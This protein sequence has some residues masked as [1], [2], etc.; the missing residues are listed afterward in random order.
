MQQHYPQHRHRH[1]QHRQQAGHQPEQSEQ[2]FNTIQNTTAPDATPLSTVNNTP[3]SASYHPY[4][5]RPPTGHSPA[6]SSSRPCSTSDSST[7]VP[8][9]H[10]N[11]IADASS[12]TKTPIASSPPAT[13]ISGTAV[14]S[15]HTC[16]TARSPQYCET[17]MSKS[18]TSTPQHSSA[19]SPT[20][21]HPSRPSLPTPIAL[22][23]PPQP[24]FNIVSH[25]IKDTLL[26]VSSLLSLLVHKNDEHFNP[27]VDPI[28]L[29]HS[30]AVPRI[31]VEAYLSRILQFIPFTN[32][33]LLNVLVY[34]DRIGGLGGMQMEL[35]ETV[36]RTE[37]NEQ[38]PS[39][40]A[41]PP[42]VP[43]AA[44]HLSPGPVKSS[45][46]GTCHRPV[47]KA[48]ATSTPPSRSTSSSSFPTAPSS[49]ACSSCCDHSF[50]A[51]S[52]IQE[53]PDS[54]PTSACNL[55][56][57]SAP[58][59]SSVPSNYNSDPPMVHKR[60]RGEQGHE[61]RE[62]M[63]PNKMSP[64]PSQHQEN[65]NDQQHP[66]KKPKLAGATAEPETT[67]A[68]VSQPAVTIDTRSTPG[69]S[70]PAATP[71]LPMAANGFRV[72]SFNIHRLLITCLMV[73]AKFTS[74]HF[75]SNVRYAKVGGLS[76]LELNQLELEFLFT[77]RFELNVKVEEL[78][79]VGNALLRF[80]NLRNA[81]AQ[82][83]SQRT[84]S[85]HLDQHIQHTPQATQSFS[86][87]GSDSGNIINTAITSVVATS[88]IH[89][90]ES[91]YWVPSP[92]SPKNGPMS[93]RQ[94]TS[95]P[96]SS[97]STSV[98]TISASES[99]G[100]PRV[101]P[102]TVVVAVESGTQRAQLLSPPE[103]KQ[104]WK[105]ADIQE[106]AERIDQTPVPEQAA[107]STSTATAAPVE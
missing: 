19:P 81:R 6:A 22:D 64:R 15:Q 94:A 52:K 28:T 88:A 76:L 87:S 50:P 103:E 45:E 55:C 18:N 86:S 78:Q 90:K 30:R 77:T 3:P 39:P 84:A 44:P 107:Q 24:Q 21:H 14:A 62:T 41:Q 1:H 56:A 92:T 47:P 34:L 46:C 17:C 105:G 106:S 4:S 23:L 29:F 61:G 40:A 99:G 68:V 42:L 31:S 53:D 97:S 8:C 67:D 58:F 100:D 104:N 36:E 51:S 11:S 74:D 49:S 91:R 85:T 101:N 33:V 16:Q 71:R 102:T 75:Y 59:D 96:L 20:C 60:G 80:R 25:P 10:S 93:D 5:P 89:L 95:A 57:V 2:R 13:P 26:I 12:A 98:T 73:A 35:I 82:H 9:R 37:V 72:N 38:S 32:E 48:C 27:Q 54:H 83:Q 7:L 66:S 69:G 43:R 63:R 70:T 65:D 79:R